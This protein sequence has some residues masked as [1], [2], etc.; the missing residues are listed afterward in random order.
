MRVGSRGIRLDHWM[1]RTIEGGGRRM[2]GRGEGSKSIVD[3]RSSLVSFDAY[4][5]SPALACEGVLIIRT[6]FPVISTYS[7]RNSIESNPSSILML[8]FLNYK[9]VLAARKRV[10]VFRKGVSKYDQTRFPSLTLSSK[11]AVFVVL[12]SWGFAPLPLFLVPSDTS[13]DT[14]KAFCLVFS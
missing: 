4:S 1:R 10:S 2:R 11:N 6:P 8:P 7:H 12:Y 5:S 14:T 3:E 9:R 13:Q